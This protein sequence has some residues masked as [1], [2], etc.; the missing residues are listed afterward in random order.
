VLPEAV[1][2]GKALRGFSPPFWFSASLFRCG[3]SKA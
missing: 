2:L 1:D 3:L